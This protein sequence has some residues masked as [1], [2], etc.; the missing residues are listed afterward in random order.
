MPTFCK[1]LGNAI[2]IEIETTYNFGFPLKS[3]T[4]EKPPTFGYLHLGML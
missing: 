4:I 3:V 1:L 2:A